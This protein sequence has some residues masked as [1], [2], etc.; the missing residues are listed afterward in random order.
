MRIL[1]VEDEVDLAHTLHTGLTAEG[2][3]VDLAHD[4]RQG[5]WMART[6][7][8]ALVVMDLMLPGL[9]G[10]K[11]C[12]Q[13][14]REGNATPILVLT[15]KDGE[16]DQ[17]EALD[18]GA[19]D[20]L[21]K[22]FSYLVLVARLRALVR[23]AAAVAPPVLAVGDLSL[24]VAGRIC[25]RAG[26]RVDLT[27]R[28]FAVLELLA[29]RAGQAVPKS[30]LLY[31]AWPDE[32]LDPNLVEARVS[33]LRKKVDT[34]FDRQSLQTVRGTGYRLVDDRERD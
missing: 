33:T 16:W 1:V 2:Y 32:A 11:V 23:R 34:A 31:H 3:S 22:P 4:G 18:T 27:P 12:A 30:D 8:Y 28:E 14:R 7:E 13:L 24:D 26:T 9:N 19:D 20:Y 25:R 15:A 29:R 10:Y 5:L 17:A 21:A 6:G